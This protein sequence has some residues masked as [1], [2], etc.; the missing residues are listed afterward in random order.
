MRRGDGV[1]YWRRNREPIPLKGQT[2]LNN[3]SLGPFSRFHKHLQERLDLFLHNMTTKWLVNRMNGVL[4]RSIQGGHTANMVAFRRFEFDPSSPIEN[5]LPMG[6]SRLFWQEERG[7]FHFEIPKQ[8]SV[9]RW[10]WPDGKIDRYKMALISVAGLVGQ[11]ETTEVNFDYTDWISMTDYGG[12]ISLEVKVNPDADYWLVML[13]LE[14]FQEGWMTTS[15]PNYV[16]MAV[17]AGAGEI[18]K[19]KLR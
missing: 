19:D 2:A 16:R 6:R 7:V 3:E 13:R 9:F 8:E 4:L 5:V 12:V 18:D 1:S 14:M 10:S 15:G 11:A 17:L